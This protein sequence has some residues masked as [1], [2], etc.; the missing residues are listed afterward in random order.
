MQRFETVHRSERI[1]VSH[2]KL[3]DGI[4]CPSYQR[5]IEGTVSSHVLTIEQPLLYITWL[6]GFHFQWV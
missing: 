4:G 3:L 2:G 5:I 6:I 1:D